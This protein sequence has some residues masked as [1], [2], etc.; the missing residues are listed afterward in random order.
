M[1][2]YMLIFYLVE[3]ITNRLDLLFFIIRFFIILMSFTVV[4]SIGFET[5]PILFFSSLLSLWELF[6]SFLELS[7]LDEYF[8][9]HKG[10]GQRIFNQVE[11]PN[12]LLS[13]Y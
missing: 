11:I 7:F 4:H 8:Y 13:I 2:F 10:L 6:F 3:V 5:L 12:F 9:L 1:L